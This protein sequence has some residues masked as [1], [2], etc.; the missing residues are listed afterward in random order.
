MPSHFLRP[1]Y[2]NACRSRRS[3]RTS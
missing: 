1:D 2:L 3:A